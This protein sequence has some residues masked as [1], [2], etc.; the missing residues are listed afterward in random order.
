MPTTIITSGDHK[1]VPNLITAVSEDSHLSFLALKD[2]LLDVGWTLIETSDGT[3]VSASD[4]AAEADF[5]N[6]LAW[7]HLRSPAGHDIVAQ[8]G[9]GATGTNW[10][11]WMC[12]LPMTGG[13]PTSPPAHVESIQMLGVGGGFN[14]QWGADGNR[15]HL[16]ATATPSNGTYPFSIMV[17]TNTNSL[18]NFQALESF[19]EVYDSASAGLPDEARWA[20]TY[21]GTGTNPIWA[22]WLLRNQ[23]GETLMT[24]LDN[25]TYPQSLTLANMNPS[26]YSGLYLFGPNLIGESSSSP[27]HVKGKCANIMLSP[28]TTLGDGDTINLTT[29]GGAFVN[30]GSQLYRW[31]HNVAPVV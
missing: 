1:F 26:P 28:D 30:F 4:F 16:H 12:D 11:M 13:T 9:T 6:D 22:A 31:P 19:Q 8:R 7:M 5:Q 17:R 27:R 25:V 10:A 21:G 15:Y 2:L 18:R 14:T 3:V 20:V 24:A 29:E 23:V